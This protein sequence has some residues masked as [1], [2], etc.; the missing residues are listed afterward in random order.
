MKKLSVLIVDDNESDRYLL[1]R[2]LNKL[3]N[4][5]PIFEAN[6]GQSALDFFM[7]NDNKAPKTI[8]GYPPVLVFLDVNMPIINGFDFLKKFAALREKQGHQTLVF[9]MLTSSGLVEE[10]ERALAY[11]FVKDYI[12]KGQVDIEYLR[13]KVSEHCNSSE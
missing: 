6:D 12:T 5:G 1:K 4:I 8:E 7:E 10:R 2:Y 11:P 9:M 13:K 3:E